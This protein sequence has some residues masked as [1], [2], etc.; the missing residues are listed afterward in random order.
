MAT[1][2]DVDMRL[3]VKVPMRDGVHLSTDIYLPGTQGTFPTVRLSRDEL[4]VEGDA[5]LGVF[6]GVVR[7]SDVSG[8]GVLGR[9]QELHG[10]VTLLVLE[11]VFLGQ[12]YGQLG[13]GD[14]AGVLALHVWTPP[15]AAICTAPPGDVD[16]SDETLWPWRARANRGI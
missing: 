4:S 1:Y 14:V 11:A 6:G 12:R 3:G 13:L 8:S 16:A 15:A 9:L 2:Y 5:E 10:P 7:V